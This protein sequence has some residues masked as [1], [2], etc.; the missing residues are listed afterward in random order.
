MSNKLAEW[1]CERRKGVSTQNKDWTMYC[2]SGGEIINTASV[3]L[4]TVGQAKNNTT[5][6]MKALC[7]LSIFN[8][9]YDKNFLLR[10]FE[11]ELQRSSFM[12]A[13][14]Y[15]RAWS[16]SNFN[17][18][19]PFPNTLHY[20][21]EILDFLSDCLSGMICSK[22]SVSFQLEMTLEGSSD[23]EVSKC[24]YL[25]IMGGFKIVFVSFEM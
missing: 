20:L 2:G 19:F 24:S 5:D 16:F 9:Q 8:H 23:A 4:V 7:W 12:D 3:T 17:R 14:P 1:L 21:K 6:V 11:C 22:T 15:L 10:R 25:H 18:A 13:F